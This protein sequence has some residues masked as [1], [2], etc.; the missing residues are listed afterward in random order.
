L[1][2]AAAF[3]FLFDG[4]GLFDLLMEALVHL[5]GGG[6]LKNELIFDVTEYVHTFVI[7][8]V[9][10]ITAIGLYQHFIEEIEVVGWL[11]IEGTEDLE[12]SLMGV[13]VVVLAVNFMGGDH[14]RETASLFAYGAGIALVLMGRLAREAHLPSHP[15]LHSPATRVWNSATSDAQSAILL[16]T[17]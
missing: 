3:F 12:R 16:H 15:H 10:Y 9:L 17:R 7:G 2:V 14:R 6:K 8:T 13:T 1:R 11:R 5:S 4:T